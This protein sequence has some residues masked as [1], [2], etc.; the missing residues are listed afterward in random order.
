M[1]RRRSTV[2]A[3][4]VGVL[5]LAGLVWLLRPTP[6]GTPLDPRGT[7]AVGTAA[8]VRLVE[9]LG[10]TVEV[11]DTV[12]DG[13]D[14]V[15]VVLVDR[16]DD[17]QRE[18]VRQRVEDGARL[19]LLDPRSPLSPVEPSGLLVTDLV[20][21]V[22]EAP[23]CPLLDGYVDRVE[24]ARWTVF[25]PTT[26]TSARCFPVEGGFGLLVQ[27]QGDGEVVV[28][29]VADALVNREIGQA[30]HARLAAALLQPDEVGRVTV[31]WDAT[32]GGGDTEL[33]DLVPGSLRTAFWVLVVGLVLY[34]LARARRLGR[35][36]AEEL[37][38][39]VPASELALSIG[40]LLARHGHRDAAA[41][42]LR[43]DLRQEVATALHVPRD[44]PPDVLAEL[45]AER[46]GDDLDRAGLHTALV[47]APVPDDESLVAVTA[48]LARVRRRL[49]AT[50]GAGAGRPGSS[51][52][53]R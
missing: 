39:R 11:T 8:M 53:G 15:L 38:V 47:D 13:P 17:G 6:S 24:S 12:P 1:T 43:A 21:A 7:D 3:V 25:E 5:V 32:V 41:A 2:V 42:R 9:R 10:A 31:V 35:P 29:G 36:V 48:A 20:G 50:A 30:H 28:T 34:A 33:L 37:P 22:G 52:H 19:V 4:A 40:E 46:A 44:T 18:A 49:R 51:G 45:L 14:Q 27:P 23:N 26:A 16:L